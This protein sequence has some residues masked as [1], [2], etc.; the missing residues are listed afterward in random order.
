MACTEQ[1]IGTRNPNARRASGSGYCTGL[2]RMK[3]ETLNAA[4]SDT[5]LVLASKTGDASNTVQETS[6]P[7]GLRR[8]M[9][10]L[11]TGHVSAM[12]DYIVAAAADSPARDEA[13]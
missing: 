10:R 8:E 12:R 11:W 7:D 3:T 2:R 1:L 9:R 6:I 13:A 5:L 4:L